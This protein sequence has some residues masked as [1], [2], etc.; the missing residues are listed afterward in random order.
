MIQEYD[1]RTKEFVIE[2]HQNGW[3][4]R[5]LKAILSINEVC[6]KSII[7]EDKFHKL[8]MLKKDKLRRYQYRLTEEHKIHAEEF[9]AKRTTKRITVNDLRN[10][11]NGIP[12][13][14]S[15][16]KSGAYIL[17]KKIMKYSFKKAHQIPK[18]MRSK[19][20][21]RNFYEAAFLQ[22]KLKWLGYKLIFADEFHVSFKDSSFYN[23]S[24]RSYPAVL[25]VNPDSW[26][27]S[28][29]IEI[30]ST[31]VEGLMAS[32]GSII[33]KTFSLFINEICEAIQDREIKP[34]RHYLYL[35]MHPCIATK[36]LQNL[37]RRMK[38]DVWP[39]LLTLHSWTLK[40]K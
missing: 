10:Y 20:N 4:H 18:K 32:T 30:S 29:V 25:A 35:T 38:S 1:R 31:K 33:A 21:C 13:I 17:L 34:E 7:N 26:T 37:Y 11:L 19:E 12:Q 15:I 28:F 36:N 16:S 8:Q 2:M 23:W 3:S 9:I 40:R 5:K 24:R 6:L 22:H 14:N 39:Y 27:M